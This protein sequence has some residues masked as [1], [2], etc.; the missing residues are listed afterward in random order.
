MFFPSMLCDEEALWMIHGRARVAMPCAAMFL[1]ALRELRVS[2]VY[3][4]L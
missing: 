2:V 3:S 4:A 1:S